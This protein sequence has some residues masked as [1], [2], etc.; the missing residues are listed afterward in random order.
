MTV[1]LAP[2]LL[3]G[4]LFALV[5]TSAWIVLAPPFA[6]S[7]IPS[8]VK[9]IISASIALFLAPSL[10]GHPELFEVGPF[11]AGIA[12][13]AFIGLAL[14][15]TVLVIFSAVQAAGELVDLFSGFSAAQLYDPFSNAS[16]SP[17]GRLYQ[18]VAIG[19]LFA[20]NGHLMLVRGFMESFQAAPLA[21]PR[22]DDLARL[23]THDVAALLV[24]AVEMA[25]PLLAA[26]FLTELA[27]GL[28]GRAAPQTNVLALSFG[29][30]IFVVLVLAGIA[31]P[32]L[33]GAV[34]DITKEI[35][36]TSTQLVRG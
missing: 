27:M 33:P 16:A 1:Q 23:F 31:L 34:A 7:S 35:V 11:I 36:R 30:K 13:Q 28:L 9:V 2:E 4:F 18:M 22:L 8:R 17:M 6:S 12:Y 32:L 10:K 21:G 14:G 3:A 29:I 24:S 15:F 26:L 20:M 5:R 19:L 25:A